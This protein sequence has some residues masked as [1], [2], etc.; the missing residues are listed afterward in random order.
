[1]SE[2]YLAMTI[3]Q[4][5]VDTLLAT[6]KTIDASLPSLIELTVDQ[7]KSL[8][9]YSDKELGFIH[10]TLQIAEQHPEIYPAN[11]NLDIMRRDVD[12]LQKLDAIL[13]AI[14]VLSG[15][16]QDSRFAAASQSVTH[17]RAVYQFV[18]THNQL[19]GG[20]EDALAD[21]SKQYAHSKPAK[22]PS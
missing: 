21:L 16:L 9:H 4:E 19:T 5:Q 2:Q 22:V 15:K 18:K 3:T 1:M 14:V 7:R 6:I 12:T 11:F 10:K 13:Y 20:L 8:P 17:A